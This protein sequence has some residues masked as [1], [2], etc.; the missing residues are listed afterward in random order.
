MSGVLGYVK[1]SSLVR[2][3]VIVT[4]LFLSVG[5]AS[6]QSSP[7]RFEVGAQVASIRSS[8]FDATDTGV[9]GR[10]AWLASSLFSVEGE[11]NFFPSD[12]PG[13]NGFSGRRLE[14][15]FGVTVGP[16]FSR[17]RPFAKFRPGLVQVGESSEPMACILIF[18]PPLSCTLASGRTLAAFDIGGGLQI[19]APA[20]TFFRV[21]AGDR[22]I[23]YPG[24]VFDTDFTVRDRSFYSHD[25]RLSVGGGLRF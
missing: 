14:A 23:R 12:F 11:V 5:R 18:P 24:Q 19:E 21:D 17:V 3:A 20:R 4:A 25:F 13:T 22:M 10:A 7:A 8:E 2:A 6:A 1:S 9:G 15:L 16:T